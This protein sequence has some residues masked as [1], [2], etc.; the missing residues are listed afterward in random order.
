MAEQCYHMLSLCRLLCAQA[1]W[2]VLL[3]GLIAALGAAAGG[4]IALPTL[5]SY[6][7]RMEVA[8]VLMK[9]GHSLS[10]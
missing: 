10:G 6:S 5:A 1:V 2:H 8:Q 7:L 9:V 4:L 3:D